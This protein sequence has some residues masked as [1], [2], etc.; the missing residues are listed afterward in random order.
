MR[1]IDRLACT[2]LCSLA[3]LAISV[4]A[5]ADEDVTRATL[6]NGLRV[7]IVRDALAP[8]VSTEMTYLAGSDEAPRGFP[9]MAH[10]QEHMMFR[11]SKG[12]STA[13]LADISAAIGGDMNAQTENTVTRY[14]YTVP[15]NRLDIALHI[16]AIRMRGALDTQADWS[17]ERGA[18]EQEVAQDLSNPFYRFFSTALGD[19][20]KGTPYEHDALGTRPSFQKTTGAALKSFYDKWYHPNN[21]LLVIAGDVDPASA[22][23]RVKRL[24][25]GIPKAPLPARMP[26][27]LRPLAPARIALDTDF[28]FS[29][30]LVAYRMPGYENADWAAGQVLQDVLASRRGE[31]YALGAS[32][33]ALAGG[34]FPGSGLPKSA[35]GFAYAAVAP[36]SDASAAVKTVKDV[37]A[38]YVVS[39]VPQDLVEASKRRLLA[40]AAFSRNSIS[41]LADA[42]TEALAIEGRSSPQDDVAAIQKVTKADVDAVAHRYL[43]NDSAVVG[44]LTPK[45]SGKAVAGKGF[46]GAESFAP[47]DTKPTTLPDWAKEVLADV[48]VPKSDLNPTEKVLANGIHVI[49]QRETISPTVTVV[50]RVKSNADLEEPQGKEGVS[51]VLEGL[52]SYGTQTKDRLAFQKALDDIGAQESVGSRFSLS[53]LSSHFDE[54]VQ[55]LADNVLHPALPQSAFTI[56]RTQTSQAL[57]GELQSPE[58]L[59]Q[60]ALNG[61][62][63]PKGDPVQREATPAGVT[64]L[65]VD[66]VKAYYARAFRPDLTTIVV[67]G[68]VTAEQAQASVAKWFSAWSSTGDR[69][70]TDL[71]P[72]PLNQPAASNVPNSSRVQD[73]VQMAETLALSR[74]DPDYYALQVGD[75]VLG[76][77]FYATRLY[78]DVRQQEGLA[79]YVGNQ[80]NVGK[81][82]ATYT[83]TFGSDPEKVGKVRS[84]IQ[85]DLRAMQTAPVTANELRLAKALLLQEIPLSESSEDS[86]ASGLLSASIDGLPLNEPELAARRYASVTA[87]QI[88]AAFAKWIR[89]D[90]FVE[91]VQGPQPH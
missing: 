2:A 73:A 86:I 20:Y 76:G 83:V 37:V 39:G 84:I 53:V 19:I 30:S 61:A 44:V 31:L 21:A 74:S 43:H 18:I 80:L 15:A 69:P 41:G 5:A 70:Q 4:R 75:H 16:E 26:V 42:W 77:A 56:V 58:Y 57:S 23:D 62:L 40:Q 35:A 28:P 89:P 12:L 47:K 78:R 66:D 82:R 52:F 25:S 85:R 22:L 11:S 3:L 81:T 27:R 55:L 50:G 17:E 36:G 8:V 7:V 14:F 88:Q 79:Y 51:L 48:S 65:S 49:V 10:A 38:G 6:P 24:F 64:A 67:I 13:Q 90:G 87:E 72:V 29:L 33:K 63:Y 71:P 34:F 46:G 68:D 1:F 91:V 32:G 9:G 59:A 54:G 60:R 45:P